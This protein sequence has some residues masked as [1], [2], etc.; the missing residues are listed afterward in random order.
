MSTNM[1]GPRNHRF[2]L[3]GDRSVK[4]GI[5]LGRKTKVRK[6]N[7]RKQTKEG[8][9]LLLAQTNH[10]TKTQTLKYIQWDRLVGHKLK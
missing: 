8:K 10:L 4:R 3:R 9:H 2:G 5:Y 1:H 6:G 7:E